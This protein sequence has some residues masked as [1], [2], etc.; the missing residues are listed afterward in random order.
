MNTPAS[1]L[2]LDKQL[3][4]ALYSSS[5][6]MTKAYKPL[7]PDLGVTYPQYLVMLALWQHSPWAWV[8][9]ANCLALTRAP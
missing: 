9:W 7:L 2:H 8:K 3:Y 6:A 5:L 1:V 4:L